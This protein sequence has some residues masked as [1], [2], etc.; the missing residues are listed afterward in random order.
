MDI[1]KLTTK[2]EVRKLNESDIEA[3]YKVMQENPLYFQHCPPRATHQSILDEK[4]FCKDRRGRYSGTVHSGCPVERTVKR[5]GWR[6]FEE[7]L[8]SIL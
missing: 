3:V 5:K 8:G 4:R 7:G 1:Q 6:K 2:F